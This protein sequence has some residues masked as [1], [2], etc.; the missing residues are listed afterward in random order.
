[1]LRDRLHDAWFR[2]RALFNRNLQ[3]VWHDE[4]LRF[5]LEQQI[6]KYVSSGMEPSEAVRQARLHFGSLEQAQEECWEAR[7]LSLLEGFVQDARYAVRTLRKSPG[8]TASAV[9]TLALGIGA[10]TAIFTVVNSVLLNPLPYRDPQ[11]LVAM[12]QNDSLLNLQDIQRANHSFVSGGGINTQPMDFTGGPEPL[13]VRGAFVDA[14]FLQTLGATPLMGRLIEAS[15]D[16]K[17]GPRNVVVSYAFWKNFLHGDPQVLGK[18]I[19][20]SGNSY[21]VIGVL[22][23]NFILPRERA[24]LFVALGGLSGGGGGTSSAFHA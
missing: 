21:T 10:N 16:V 15:E 2:F 24:D 22:P 17:G 5:H 3:K 13:Q 1:M 4:E 20:L 14:G 23:R 12:K 11:E 9:L 18:S 7:G 6:A 8:F 19:S